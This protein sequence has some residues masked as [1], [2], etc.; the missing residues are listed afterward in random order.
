MGKRWHKLEFTKA[1]RIQE[2]SP[3]MSASPSGLYGADHLLWY[4]VS[5]GHIGPCLREV[6]KSCEPSAGALEIGGSPLLTGQLQV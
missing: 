1:S 5:Y 6:Y 3:V 2:G 4:C